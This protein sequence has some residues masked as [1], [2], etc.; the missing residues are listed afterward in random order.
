MKRWWSYWRIFTCAVTARIPRPCLFALDTKSCIW[1]H[2]PKL[3]NSWPRI[4][5]GS[6]SCSYCLAFSDGFMEM[7]KLWSSDVI[8]DLMVATIVWPLVPLSGRVLLHYCQSDILCATVVQALVWWHCGFCI[9]GIHSLRI[10]NVLGVCANWVTGPFC[11]SILLE[12]VR[13]DL[14]AEPLIEM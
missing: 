13:L 3:V 14:L 11:L 2:R 10:V 9:L 4:S 1:K 6:R 5:N 7:F 12:A 8:R